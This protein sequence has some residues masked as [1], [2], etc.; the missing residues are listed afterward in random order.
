[1]EALAVGVR[2]AEPALF[3]ECTGFREAGNPRVNGAIVRRGD[4]FDN[5][6]LEVRAGCDL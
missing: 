3:L 5:W 6:D 4:S 2:Q 1:M